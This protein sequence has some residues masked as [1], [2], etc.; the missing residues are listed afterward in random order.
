[1]S[2]APMD[3]KDAQ[4]APYNY[5]TSET[6]IHDDLS[7]SGTLTVSSDHEKSIS[8]QVLLTTY[9][10]G[11]LRAWSVVVGVSTTSTTS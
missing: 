4:E 7:L 10:E 6:V 1:M 9:P 2:L 5:P 11:G 3:H 8:S